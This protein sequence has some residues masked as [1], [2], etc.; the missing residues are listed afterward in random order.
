MSW[1]EDLEPK[2]NKAGNFVTGFSAGT[3]YTAKAC[4]LLDQCRK[5]AGCDVDPE[6][7]SVILADPFLNSV[8]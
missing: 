3:N 2:P 6:M 5:S 1:I 4:E 7:L 8:S